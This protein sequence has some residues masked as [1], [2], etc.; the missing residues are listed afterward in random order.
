MA[1]SALKVEEFGKQA[2]GVLQEKMQEL[3]AA[4]ERS[5]RNIE[6]CKGNVFRL[7]KQLQAESERYAGN[8][9]QIQDIPLQID[10]QEARIQL[11][12]AHADPVV[13][14][15]R[16][17]AAKATFQLLGL[18]KKLDQAYEAAEDAL[19]SKS[20]ARLYSQVLNQAFVHATA[21]SK[22]YDFFFLSGY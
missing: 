22:N 5:K 17:S 14:A 10:L 11:E 15:K 9:G 1:D 18:I 20:Q 4:T 3:R 6:I 2:V 7:C 19:H 8:L 13:S 21:R 16:I 12:K